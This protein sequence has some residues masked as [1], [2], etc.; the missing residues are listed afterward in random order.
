MKYQQIYP[1]VEINA[2]KNFGVNDLKSAKTYKQSQY[3]VGSGNYTWVMWRHYEGCI[4]GGGT[5]IGET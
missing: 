1:E 4:P 5:Y 3:G 2:K